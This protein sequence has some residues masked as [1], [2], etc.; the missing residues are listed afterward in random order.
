MRCQ[1]SSGTE[2]EEGSRRVSSGLRTRAP[3]NWAPK[4]TARLVFHQA[5]AMPVSAFAFFQG[6]SCLGHD[7][8]WELTAELT[9]T[10]GLCLNAEQMD[11]LLGLGGSLDILYK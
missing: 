4:A 3:W 6:T 5:Q 1:Y 7:W 9:V 8:G 11:R 2:W 10:V